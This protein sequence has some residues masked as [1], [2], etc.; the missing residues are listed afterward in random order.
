MDRR[1]LRRWVGD[2][3]L[4]LVVGYAGVHGTIAAQHF[5]PESRHLDMLGS[6]LIV[7]AAAPL[8]VRRR[9]PL[10]TLAL[11]SMVTSTYLEFGYAY[12]PILLSLL[13]AVYTVARWR[14]VR[15]ASSRTIRS[16]YRRHLAKGIGAARPPG[17]RNRPRRSLAASRSWA[18][19]LL[20]ARPAVMS[21]VLL[22][23]GCRSRDT[24]IVRVG[25]PEPCVPPSRLRATAS[26]G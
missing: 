12:G 20:D 17:A 14:T 19:G 26:R 15:R 13:V 16:T 10:V 7:A 18:G 24:R 1:A 2:A 11:V 5:Q 9:W 25:G 6:A 8:V 23:C 22:A 3:V 4:A 21:A